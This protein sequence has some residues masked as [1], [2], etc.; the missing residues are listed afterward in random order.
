MMAKEGEILIGSLYIE[1]E[2]VFWPFCE[3][4]LSDA[5]TALHPVEK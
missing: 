5:C 3:P 2:T 4:V 1:D